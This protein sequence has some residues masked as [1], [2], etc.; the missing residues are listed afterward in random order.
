VRIAVLG[1]GVMGGS[2][3]R[4]WLA[5]DRAV[6]GW[7]P[8]P[9]DR[10]AAASAGVTVA[11]GP[12]DCVTD[13]DG[14]FLAA[15]L[16]S[17]PTLISQIQGHILPTAWI[18]D[19]GSLQCPPLGLAAES[20][21]EDRWISCHPMAGSERSGFAA[22][23]AN[24]YAGARVWMSAADSV[25]RDSRDFALQL[26]KVLGSDPAWIDPEEHDRRMAWVSH[27]PQVVSVAVADALMSAGHTL[28][29][30]GPGGRDVTRLAA[31]S[32][33][34][35]RELLQQAGPEV[36]RALR[37]VIE[38]LEEDATGLEASDPGPAIERLERSGPW[39]TE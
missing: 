7:A 19:V 34:M 33:G 22:S 12:G 20:G 16:G 10:T 37:E 36:A 38:R 28:D 3:A 9:E 1:L 27:L 11:E 4:G 13:A 2:I 30:L 39:R 21:L 17:F 14:I 18:M 25:D 35:W 26:W 24:L 29:E 23:D 15:P 5:E 31:S 6:S 8:D 32:P